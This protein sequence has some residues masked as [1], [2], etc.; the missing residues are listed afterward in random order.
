MSLRQSLV[1]DPRLDVCRRRIENFTLYCI[2]G[3]GGVGVLSYLAKLPPNFCLL[4]DVRSELLSIDPDFRRLPHHLAMPLA[5]RETTN[6]LLA[7]VYAPDRRVVRSIGMANGSDGM[8]QRRG[9][10]LIAGTM[11]T[12]NASFG[13]LSSRLRD[14]VL[15]QCHGAPDQITIVVLGSVCGGTAAGAA[16]P[17]ARALVESLST[18]GVP[19]AVEFDMLDSVSYATLG[20]NIHTNA[21]AASDSLLNLIAS[22]GGDAKAEQPGVFGSRRSRQFEAIPKHA[23]SLW[24]SN[25]RHGARRHCRNTFKQ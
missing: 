16:E 7:K 12:Q 22:K 14:E 8:G 20:P 2:V 6:S 23:R 21:A 19:I 1:S 25:T 24:R 17:I 5:D 4:V 11:L 3:G 13:E 10:G 15:A 9:F 18:L